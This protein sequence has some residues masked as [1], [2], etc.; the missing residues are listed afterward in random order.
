MAGDSQTNIFYLLLSPSTLLQQLNNDGQFF[1][2]LF[3]ACLPLWKWLLPGGMQTSSVQA[4]SLK[5]S[6]AQNQTMRFPP[7][8]DAA[9]SRS[10]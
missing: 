1:T 4:E 10:S 2:L 9:S 6:K 5:A 8:S 3:I 7:I